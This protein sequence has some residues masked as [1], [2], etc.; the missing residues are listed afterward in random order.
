MRTLTHLSVRNLWSRKLRTLV[1]GFGIVL[2]VATVLAFGIA[3]ATVERSLNDFFS[4][5]AGEA[6]LTI[7]SSD[8]GQVFRERAV[9][10]AVDFPGVELAVG[11]LWKGG[12]LRLPD[13]DKQIALVGI[14]PETDPQVRSYQLAEGRMIDISDRT[15]SI[16]LAAAFAEDNGIHL[17]DDLEIEL[18]D[19][20][21]EIF[22]VVGLLANQGVARLN[23]GAIGFSRLDV[24][25]DLFDESGRLSQVE[26]V[27]SPEITTDRD[28]LEQLKDDL[29][30]YLGDDYTVSY[31]AAVG[32]AIIDSLAGLRAGLGI[33]STVA[34]FVGAMLIYNTFS[35]TLAERT[36]EI[37]ILRAVGAVRG[38]ILRLALAEAALLGLIG[39]T[40]GLGLGAFLAIPMVQI[41]AQAFGGIPLDRFSVPPASVVLSVLVGIMVTLLAGLVP[42]IQASRISPVEAMQVRAASR[43]TFLARNGWKI[44]LALMAF[45]LGNAFL[46]ALSTLILQ[47]APF[48]GDESTAG[49]RHVLSAIL[50]V[51][52]L[53]VTAPRLLSQVSRLLRQPWV[54][55]TQRVDR[56]VINRRFRF[57]T[58]GGWVIG[59][60]LLMQGLANLTPI[61]DY[62]PDAS[63]FIF[64]FTGGT[65]LMPAVI[66]L[67]ERS[68]RRLLSL[69]YGPAGGLGSRNL[70]RARGRTSLTIGVLMVGATLT[71]AIGSLQA[72]FDGAI[73]EWVDKTLGGDLTVAAQ[74]G[75]RIDFASQLMGIPGVELATPYSL[76]SV[77]MTGIVNKFGFS[78][79]SNSLGFQAVDLPGY[80]E[81]SGFQFMEDAEFED[82]MLAHL[83]RG[84]AVLVSGVLSDE[85][86]IHRGDLIRLRTR[87]GEHDFEVAGVIS[88]FNWGGRSVVAT[89]SDMERYLGVSQASLFLVKLSPGADEE[90]I[91]RAL[92]TRLS[93]YGE[94]EVESAVKFRETISRD[95]SSLMAVFNVVV[96]IAVLVGGLGVINTMT[97]NILERV[98]EIGMLRAVGMTRAQIGR[99]VLAEA[100]AMGVIGGAFGLGIGWLIAEDMVAA[101]EA[102]SGWQFDFTF[103]VAAFM[104]AAITSVVVSQLAALYPVWR[105]GGMRIVEAIQHE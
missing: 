14:H 23:N 81:L 35:M 33:F 82:E 59:L 63:F 103:P 76:I 28:T 3:N 1:T 88:N 58:K 80:R 4:Q 27:L 55:A 6:D 40:I 78:A 24:V 47:L 53:L 15:Y 7:S 57:F 31:P 2:G 74:R 30:T 89:W 20:Q 26:V 10:E 99:M 46:T 18:A 67:L 56:L 48:L 62:L 72:A 38:Q 25:Q 52:G 49:L 34:L 41:F 61:W 73:S 92:E 19:A 79:E 69:L 44:G 12:D 22:E 100:A 50:L 84:G 71:I 101:M 96:Y 5:T 64:T 11:S 16:V 97:M 104:S 45:S 39:S 29:A 32:Q 68:A 36:V 21:V 66:Q 94:F 70:H 105:A 77:E 87:R 8:Q 60:A 86:D 90:T 102:G 42:A 51:V 95:A 17:G 75:Q 98:R 91:K 54:D 83:A 9:R 65:L 93:R 37:G 43:L 85:H 13:K